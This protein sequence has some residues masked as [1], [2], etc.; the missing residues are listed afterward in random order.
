MYHAGEL[1]AEQIQFF[2]RRPAETLYDLDKDP[3]ELN[4]LAG[5]PAYDSKLVEMRTLLQKQVKSMPDLSFIPEPVFLAEGRSNPVEFG[6]QKKQEIARLIDV[7]DLSLKAFPEAKQQISRALASENPWERYWGLITCGSFGE[8][9]APFYEQ[10][11]VIAA[12]DGERLVRIRAAEFL[13]L[14]GQADPRP[15]IMDVLKQVTNPTEANLILN[16]AALLE[17]SDP[18][19]DFDLSEFDAAENIN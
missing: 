4:N 11:K 8:Q 3:H 2:E 13:G 14:T 6:Q 7:A 9:A 5:D 12:S 17:N 18:G 15:V 10:A 19:Y 16:S 1:N